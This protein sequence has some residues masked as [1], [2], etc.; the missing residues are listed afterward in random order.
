MS[1]IQYSGKQSGKK[2]Q[3]QKASKEKEINR[4][5]TVI[6]TKHHSSPSY[7]SAY[8][9]NPHLSFIHILQQ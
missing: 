5:E 7:T 6:Y 1:W 3:K 2:P 8:L 9:T 4:K